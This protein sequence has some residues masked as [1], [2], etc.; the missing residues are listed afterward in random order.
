MEE[1]NKIKKVKKIKPKNKEPKI[2]VKKEKNKIN[3]K[4]IFKKY[5]RLIIVGVLAIILLIS[6]ICLIFNLINK[7]KYEDYYKYE[8]KMNVYGY[9]QLYLNQSSNTT[10][11][12]TRIEAAKMAIAAALNI[13]DIDPYVYLDINEYDDDK[14][15]EYAEQ[16]GILGDF[17]INVDNYLDEVDYM[18]V[19][20]YFKNAKDIFL[21][22][23]SIADYSEEISG[24]NN[25]TITDQIA[26]K[27]L[28][29]SNIIQI[30]DGDFD[31]EEI[32]F[33]GQLN[34]LVINFVQ[35]FSTITL[36]GEKL[37]INPD[38][39]PSNVD[40]YPYTL[41]SVDKEVYEMPFYVVSGNSAS[42]PNTIF[43][44]KNS[45]LEQ[46]V[47]FAEEYF[48]YFL[49]IDYLTIDSDTFRNNLNSYLDYNESF[50][51]I[52]EY[53]NYV[54]ENEVIITGDATAIMPVFYFDGMAHRLRLKISFTIENSNTNENL[55]YYD[56]ISSNKTIYNDETYEFYIDYTMSGMT[57]SEYIYVAMNSVYSTIVDTQEINIT[58]E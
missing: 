57:N 31:G 38:N 21:D 44:S 45:K 47:R 50:E 7:D 49:N 51:N 9:S 41:A 2:K 43:S 36:N 4:M 20:T 58:Q 23:V 54:K 56:S 19:V 32:A 46:I 48:D 26:I 15:G 8:E 29:G 10:D 22:D 34:E 1:E 17:D 12:V 6:L 5:K 18:T 28:L 3:F 13:T 11:S 55:L 53:V 30:F 14:W 35:E 42:S 52:E 33:K 39:E 25:Y 37:N 16:F 40:D 27:D 24:I